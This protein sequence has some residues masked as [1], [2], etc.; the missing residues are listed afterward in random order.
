ML[1]WRGDGHET[2]HEKSMELV[3]YQSAQ[4]ELLSVRDNRR[5]LHCGY[6]AGECL[7]ATCS[8]NTFHDQAGHCLLERIVGHSLSGMALT[9]CCQAGR[10]PC[11][12]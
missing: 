4:V 5:G 1:V 2:V 3:G 10:K 7:A 12:T 6:C 8:G 9:C 11:W